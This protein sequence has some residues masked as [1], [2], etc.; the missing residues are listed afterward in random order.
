MYG[1]SSCYFAQR[2]FPESPTILELQPGELITEVYLYYDKDR[3]YS[4]YQLIVGLSIATNRG[5]FYG[6]YGKRTATNYS[7][8]GEDLLYFDGRSAKYVDAVGAQFGKC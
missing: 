8:V 4:E 7:L 3:V 5:Q 2:T 6:V 1:R